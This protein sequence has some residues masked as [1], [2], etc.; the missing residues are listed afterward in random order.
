[1]NIALSQDFLACIA[2]A[3][4]QVAKKA[5]ETIS[6]FRIAPNAVGLNY[7]RI[8]AA[9]DKNL[10]SIRLDQDYRI[11]LWASPEGGNHVFLWLDHHDDAYQWSRN[12]RVEINPEIGAL[13]I[14][15]VQE[16]A[17]GAAAS[18]D[19]GAGPG[20]LFSSLRDR[21][22]MRLGVP[23][24]L[25]AEVRALR[26]DAEL[27]AMESRL[28]PLAFQGLF[29]VAAGYGYEEA[30]GAFERGEP[31][32]VGAES[33]DLLATPESRASFF[34]VEDDQLLEEMFN[35]PLE[36]WRVFLHPSQ[37]RLVE[38]DWNGS[39]KITGG[40]GTGKTVAA[41][42]RARW[43]AARLPAGGAQRILFTTFTKNLAQD[44]RALLACICSTDE[45]GR[46]DVQNID[47]VARDV[48]KK[49]R[50]DQTIMFESSPE[51]DELWEEAYAEAATDDLPLSFYREEW[52]YI[53]QAQQIRDLEAYK[54]ASRA[55]RKVRLTRQQLIKVWPVFEAYLSLLRR[56]GWIES[57]DAFF[58][59]AAYLRGAEPLYS[60]VIVDETQDM[61]IP[62]LSFLRALAPEGPNDLFLVG[63]AHQTIYG[64]RT[65][66][67]QAGINVRGRSRRLLLNYRTTEQIGRWALSWIAGVEYEDLDGAS[68]SLKG[69][70][71]LVSGSVPVDLRS[72]VPEEK[73][74]KLRELLSGLSPEELAS[75]CLALPSRELVQEWKSHLDTW[76][77]PARV[78]G[79]VLPADGDKAAVSISTIHRIKGLEFDRVLVR[80]P[81]DTMQNSR[82]LGFVAAT[83]A[84][85]E[86]VLL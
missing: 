3:P 13:Q 37:R 2:G 42:H 45:L 40:P 27:E 54:A 70:R 28:P 83:R 50:F 62:A 6:K 5:R 39:V 7:E 41:L 19:G 51:I 8:N 11:I 53:I 25:L 44:I 26:T 59:A 32:A 1:M 38:R 61:G 73:L 81:G 65:V 82:S 24:E 20:G 21:E 43:L 76:D 60:A 85:K 35:A 48:L 77:I 79:A 69:Y 30:V 17:E 84:R 67:S 36:R 86:L 22:L 4:A 12:R 72:L 75:T 71:S 68:D 57:Q 23:Q 58:A 15:Q 16:S 34:L 10:R 64:R 33:D 66:L 46:I 49:Y 29:L 55:G 14:Y 63:D 9:R 18:Y 74:A 78:L 31:A 47:A 52:A 56:H 80:L